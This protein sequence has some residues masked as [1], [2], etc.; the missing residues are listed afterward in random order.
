M[1]TGG[2]ENPIPGACANDGNTVN[3]IENSI[4]KK[5]VLKQNFKTAL[6]GLFTY[7]INHLF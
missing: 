4:K 2:K 1:Q 3:I 6:S 7:F 5:A